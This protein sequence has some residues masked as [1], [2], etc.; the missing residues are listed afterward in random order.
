M[1][2]IKLNRKF[3]PIIFLLTGAS[4]FG[5]AFYYAFNKENIK[6]ASRTEENENT[7]QDLSV[8]GGQV[9]EM[10]PTPSPRSSAAPTRVTT[11]TVRRI[12]ATATKTPTQTPTV[13]PS[14]TNPVATETPTPTPT[15][16]P[17]EMPTNTPTPTFSPTPTLIVQVEEVPLGGILDNSI[18]L[19]LF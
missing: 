4:V 17:T 9:F 8:A 5:G 10:S 14:P 2:V 3:L 6:I 11:P 1:A 16:T 7:D 19:D 18:S 13:T 15:A 12:S